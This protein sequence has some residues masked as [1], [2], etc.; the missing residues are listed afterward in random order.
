MTNQDFVESMKYLALIAIGI[1]DVKMAQIV[2]QMVRYRYRSGDSLYVWAGDMYSG[3]CDTCRMS[4]YLGEL[5]EYCPFCDS[6]LLPF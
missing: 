6:K 2:T 1:K 5:G 3:Q 4:W